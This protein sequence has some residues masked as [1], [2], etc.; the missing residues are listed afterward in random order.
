MCSAPRR[1]QEIN[2][3]SGVMKKGKHGCLGYVETTTILGSF[4]VETECW[5]RNQYCFGG[6]WWFAA[7]AGA[8]ARQVMRAVPY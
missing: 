8:L 5:L 6:V 3:T 4:S 7:M 2:S 1:P